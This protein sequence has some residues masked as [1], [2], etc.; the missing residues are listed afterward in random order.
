MKVVI[1]SE[2]NKFD[3]NGNLIYERVECHE[4]WYNNKGG[5]NVRPDVALPIE[6]VNSS[7]DEVLI[8]YFEGFVKNPSEGMIRTMLRDEE[9]WTA[10]YP[11]LETFSEMSQDELYENTML[12][13]PEDLLY[14]LCDGKRT[15]DD[16]LKD[17]EKIMQD[18][19]LENSSITSFEY[20]L[21]T[22]LHEEFVKKC[23]F[24]KDDTFYENE[25]NYINSKYSDVDS[26]IEIVS[27]GFLTLFEEVKPTTIFMIDFDLIFNYI[28][29]NYSP[30]ELIDKV[31]VLL[32]TTHNV[33][34]NDSD[35][36]LNHDKEF[37]EI[38]QLLSDEKLMSI[39]SMYN[40]QL[41]SYLNRQTDLEDL[42]DDEQEDNE[43]DDEMEAD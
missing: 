25:I 16:I 32:N 12:F 29:N 1:K 33:R 14:S 11:N 41:E 4:K 40:F 31:F 30:E 21:Y 18:V 9:D 10:L 19:I 35:G 28:A 17:K 23:Y 8:V 2:E 27:G 42:G 5:D 38:I 24:F 15:K 36:S 37:E 34:Y 7:R 13:L 20:S 6:S 26:K 3:K 39:T 22:L 43:G